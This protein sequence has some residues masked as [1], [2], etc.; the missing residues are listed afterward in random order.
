[1][2]RIVLIA[3]RCAPAQENALSEFVKVRASWWHYSA[4]TWLLKFASEIETVNLRDEIQAAFPGLHFMVLG[5]PD[6]PSQWNGYGPPAW[7]QWFN[8]VWE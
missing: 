7:S 1:M 4:D 3:P 2:R 6:K 5:F 8:D